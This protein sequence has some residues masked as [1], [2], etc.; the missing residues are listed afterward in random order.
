MDLSTLRPAANTA[1]AIAD[2][3]TRAEAA[4]A[5]AQIGVTEAKRRRDALLLD[6]TPAQLAAAD[7]ALVA[8]RELAERVEAVIEQLHARRADAEKSEAIGQHEAALRAYEKA[9]AARA[10]WWRR[11]APK[12]QALIRDGAAQREEVSR[13]ADAWAR[14]QEC[15]ERHHPEAELRNPVLDRKSRAWK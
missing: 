11:T 5:E 15:M 2:S 8:A 4:R 6:G 12:L 3:L 9:D 10:E 14:S 1:A 13:L 7:K